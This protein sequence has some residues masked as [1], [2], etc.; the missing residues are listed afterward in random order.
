MLTCAQLHSFSYYECRLGIVTKDW[1][2]YW[3]YN[4]LE[5]VYDQEQT[6]S[7]YKRRKDVC[8]EAPVFTSEPLS[9][10]D[11]PDEILLHILSYFGLEDLCLIIAQVCEKWKGLVK[12][13]IMWKKLFYSCNSSTDISHIKK[14]RWTAFLGF[15]VNYLTNFSSSSVLK[16]LHLKKH[17]RNWA[18]FHPEWG[19]TNF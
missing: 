8:F 18:F 2:I 10:S 11:L 17:V 3:C 5:T 1:F 14:V 7:T 19:K 4:I 15:R 16:V 13:K 6:V 12:D 9:V